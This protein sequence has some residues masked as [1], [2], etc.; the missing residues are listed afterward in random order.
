MRHRYGD[1][2]TSYHEGLDLAAPPATPVRA[3]AEG[4]VVLSERL[5]VRG[6]AVV[7]A[8]GGGFCTGYWHL[9]QR[10]VRVGERVKGGR[11]SGFSGVRG[12][13]PG[14]TCTS[15]PASRAFP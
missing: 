4:V 1:L 7:L 11:S 6:E 14:L 12:F 5:K 13:P 3:V 9:A 2:F 15:R 10:A 8:H